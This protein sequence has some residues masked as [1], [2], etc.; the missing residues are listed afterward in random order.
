MNT[1][2]SVQ[3]GTICQPNWV[4]C[5]ILSSSSGNLYVVQYLN[6]DGEEVEATVSKDKLSEEKAYNPP[7]DPAQLAEESKAVIQKFLKKVYGN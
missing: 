5:E 3:I 4:D 1:F 7:D 6:E 2:K